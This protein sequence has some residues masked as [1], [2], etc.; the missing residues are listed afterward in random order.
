MGTVSFLIR[1]PSAAEY[2]ATTSELPTLHESP[3]KSA[4]KPAAVTPVVAAVAAVTGAV[5]VAGG[6]ARGAVAAGPLHPVAMR[7]NPAASS[8]PGARTRPATIA[9]PSYPPG[10]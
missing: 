6:A 8:T 9:P 7:N 3:V 1:S 4:G 10:L 2:T 5:A